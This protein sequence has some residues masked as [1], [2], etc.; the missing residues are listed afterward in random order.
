MGRGNFEG[1]GRAIVK[2]RTFYGHLRENGCADQDA[3]W[4]VGSDGPKESCVR[5][6]SRS[7]IESGNFGE[8]GHPL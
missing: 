6:G 2:S 8:K 4:V 3:V 1:E 7:P 5:W